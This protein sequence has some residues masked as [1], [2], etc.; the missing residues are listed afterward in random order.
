[1]ADRLEKLILELEQS[2]Q[3]RLDA[4]QEIR[5]EAVGIGFHTLLLQAAGNRRIL[6]L[7]TGLRSLIRIFAMRRTG[8]TVDDLKRIHRE[9]YDVIAAIEARDPDRAGEVMKMEMEGSQRDRLEQFDLREQEAGLPRDISAYLD[10]IQAEL[11]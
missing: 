8:H 1:V 3:E 10:R 6:K 9:H 11:G 4:K 7:A 2:G 5:F